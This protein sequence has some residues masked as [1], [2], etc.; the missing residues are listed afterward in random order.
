MQ[1]AS[2]IE[3][4]GITLQEKVREVMELGDHDEVEIFSETAQI[5]EGAHRQT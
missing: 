1:V 5:E 4:T 2:T 3:D